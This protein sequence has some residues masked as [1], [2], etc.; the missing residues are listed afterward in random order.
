MTETESLTAVVSQAGVIADGIRLLRLVEATGK[1]LPPWEPGAHIDVTVPGM[2]YAV[3][4]KCPVFGGRFV[5]GNL[6]EVAKLPGVRKVFPVRNGL[7]AHMQSLYEGVAIVADG[8]HQANKALQ[9]LVVNWDEGKGATLSSVGF[10]AQ[11]AELARQPAA[12]SVR[13]DGDVDAAL[14]SAARVA[15]AVY[16]GPY[17]GLGTA[18]EEFEGWIAANGYTSASDLWE[19]YLTGPDADPDPAAWRTEL[20]RPL[21]G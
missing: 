15:Q 3:Y 4:Q 17:E 2:R 9:K 6:D 18:W 7:V 8:W 16:H 14:E 21:I 12:T 1:A 11:A 10:A 20:N 13:K 5:S 19:R